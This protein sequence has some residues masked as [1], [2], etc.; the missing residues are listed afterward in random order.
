MSLTSS[1]SFLW[2]CLPACLAFRDLPKAFT[3]TYA[4]WFAA[5]AAVW[6]YFH[7]RVGC[8]LHL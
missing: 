8:G 2:A 6:G 4:L 3:R 7:V 1:V 5:V